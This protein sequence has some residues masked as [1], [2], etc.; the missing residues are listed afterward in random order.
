MGRIA[1]GRGIVSREVM[2]RGGCGRVRGVALH[3]RLKVLLVQAE[4]WRVD[5]VIR[6]DPPAPGGVLESKPFH[7]D[8]AHLQITAPCR[9]TWERSL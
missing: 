4:G 3:M 5:D 6:G 2:W 8:S 7:V 9:D 1:R